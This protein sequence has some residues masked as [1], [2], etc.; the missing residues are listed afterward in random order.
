MADTAKSATRR[1]STI[2]VGDVVHVHGTYFFDN[3]TAPFYAGKVKSVFDGGRRFTIKW[4]E[5]GT[6]SRDVLLEDLVQPT[7]TLL[8]ESPI[9]PYKPPFITEIFTKPNIALNQSAIP[10]SPTPNEYTSIKPQPLENLSTVNIAHSDV[11]G[12]SSDEE[13]Y[14]FPPSPHDSDPNEGSEVLFSDRDDDD[15][16]DESKVDSQDDGND[17]GGEAF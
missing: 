11:E 17:S 12:S 16:G 8:P 6:V 7:P 3:P 4:N 2:L 14:G 15:E 10:D 9:I 13:F 1:A 5:D